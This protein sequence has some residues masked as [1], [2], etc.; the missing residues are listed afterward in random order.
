M[1]YARK[2]QNDLNN[3]WH[4]CQTVLSCWLQ[5]DTWWIWLWM[6]VDFMRFLAVEN[7][8]NITPNEC[9]LPV[10]YIVLKQHH[11]TPYWLGCNWFQSFQLWFYI[12]TPKTWCDFLTTTF[13]RGRLLSFIKILTNLKHTSICIL[14]NVKWLLTYMYIVFNSVLLYWPISVHE[15]YIHRSKH[16]PQKPLTCISRMIWNPW[17]FF[18]TP[19]LVSY[20][21]DLYTY[22][23]RYWYLA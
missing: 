7:F 8:A 19:S 16:T 5:V 6:G 4:T 22:I 23:T 21:Y 3:E 14:I 12:A 18:R 1:P 9:V 17:G 20:A 10:M 15:Q 2:S 11:T 13:G